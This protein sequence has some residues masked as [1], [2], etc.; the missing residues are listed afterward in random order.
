[1]KST[2]SF[3]FKDADS[4]SSINLDPK[5]S[6]DSDQFIQWD[7]NTCLARLPLGDWG[8]V[9]ALSLNIIERY[10]A[11]CDSDDAYQLLSEALLQYPKKVIKKLSD[12]T[13]RL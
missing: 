11:L 6:F 7:T 8:N 1:M 13:A 5:L 4:T 10:P 12:H 9:T 3:S 2:I